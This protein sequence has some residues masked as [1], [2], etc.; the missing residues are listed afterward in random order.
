VNPIQS[1]ILMPPGCCRIDSPPR[2]EL[3]LDGDLAGMALAGLVVMVAI[4]AR[5]KRA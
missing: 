2:T 3:V 4:V 1:I 5:R